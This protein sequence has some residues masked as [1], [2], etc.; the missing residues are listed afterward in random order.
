MKTPFGGK[1]EC[2]GAIESEVLAPLEGK[3]VQPAGKFREKR[4]LLL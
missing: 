2:K 1:T 4:R 3:R